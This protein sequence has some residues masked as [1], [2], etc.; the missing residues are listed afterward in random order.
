MQD[1]TRFYPGPG[2]L[3]LYPV[4]WKFVHPRALLLLPCPCRFLYRIYLRLAFQSGECVSTT[5]RR[6]VRF[7]FRSWSVMNHD[8]SPVFVFA[9]MQSEKTEYEVMKRRLLD[10]DECGCVYVWRMPR[11]PMP[12]PHAACRMWMWFVVWFYMQLHM[13]MWLLAKFGFLF[14]TRIA[15]ANGKSHQHRH[16]GTVAA[17]ARPWS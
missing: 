9:P 10:P 1:G 17:T 13:H 4:P 16:A 12:L 3:V 2:F 8:A 15:N 5:H 11:M 7:L 6:P 14:K